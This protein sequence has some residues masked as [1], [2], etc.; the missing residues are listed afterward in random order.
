MVIRSLSFLTVPLMA[1]AHSL[2]TWTAHA[3][4][5]NELI[6]KNWCN[7]VQ[8]RFLCNQSQGLLRSDKLL[9]SFSFSFLALSTQNCFLDNCFLLLEPYPSCATLS[10]TFLT[11]SPLATF[12]LILLTGS[13][14]CCPSSCDCS[15]CQAC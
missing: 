15:P 3:K 13:R 1:R 10:M 7:K 12:S 5:K 8:T 11:V 2:A 6:K 9:S 4:S 14:W